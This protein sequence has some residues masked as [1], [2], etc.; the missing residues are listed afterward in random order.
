MLLE[1]MAV[2]VAGPIAEQMPVS[3]GMR[4]EKTLFCQKTLLGAPKRTE[5][6]LTCSLKPETRCGRTYKRF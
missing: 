2:S 5:I 6:P 3:R 4:T 1:R